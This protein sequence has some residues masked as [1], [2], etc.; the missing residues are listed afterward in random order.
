[1]N[2]YLVRANNKT[3]EYATLFEAYSSVDYDAVFLNL[4]EYIE[5]K[6]TNMISCDDFIDVVKSLQNFSNIISSQV[7]AK[8]NVQ[9]INQVFVLTTGSNDNA[10]AKN[11]IVLENEYFMSRF[12]AL[13]KDL[14]YAAVIEKNND[15]IIQSIES[16]LL[17]HTNEL[18]DIA[19]NIVIKYN[20]N[21]CKPW[22]ISQ[23]ANTDNYT[24]ADTYNSEDKY[25]AVMDMTIYSANEYTV[26]QDFVAHISEIVN[27]LIS[28]K[29]ELKGSLSHR[30]LQLLY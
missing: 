12:N 24:F 8:Y 28:Y 21:F 9:D 27:L 13:L 2:K 16:Y 17:N 7:Q 22:A 20:T 10:T 6:F 19:S 29:D 25:R 5:L 18:L 23:I 15:F 26:L 11:I 4:K 30:L 1:M 14:G 3:D